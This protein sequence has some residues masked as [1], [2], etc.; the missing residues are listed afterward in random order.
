MY[1]KKEK[2]NMKK[3][4]ISFLLVLL[5]SVSL[6]GSILA[7][8]EDCHII[9]YESNVFANVVKGGTMSLYFTLYTTGKLEQ[10]YCVDICNSSGAAVISKTG[11]FSSTPGTE[12][13]TIS[14]DT[15]RYDFGTYTVKCYTLE[16]TTPVPDTMQTFTVSVSKSATPLKRLY[17]ADPSKPD[18][19]VTAVT[20]PLNER[21]SAYTVVFDPQNT[22]FKRDLTVTSSNPSAVEV[23]TSGGQIQFSA[24]GYGSSIITARTSQGYS[25]T[26]TVTVAKYATGI[27]IVLDSLDLPIGNTEI[28]E[29]AYTPA[30][31]TETA[32]TWSSSDSSIVSVSSTGKLTALKNGTATVTAC[33]YGQSDTCVVTVTGNPLPFTDVTSGKWY[34]N[35]VRYVY[36]NDLFSGMSPTEFGP[37]METTRAML[38]TVLWR[39]DGTPN[40]ASSSGFSDVVSNKYYTQAVAWASENNISNGISETEF[41]PELTLTREQTA[42]LLYRYAAYKGLDT[43]AVADLSTFPDGESV[44]GWALTA[45]RWAVGEELL[46]GTWTGESVLL[47]PQGSATRAQVATIIMRADF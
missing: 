37:D 33:C 42:T 17:F 47:D 13:L 44:S 8:E 34:H 35:A 25:C 32:T 18:T 21:S 24:V 20:I 4:L 39:L 45:M 43:S 41:G 46:A 11:N 22:T 12:E 40:P 9:P 30:D 6:C 26:C 14:W 1:V 27:D 5:L 28:L 31:A 2:N 38:I 19:A 3:R 36:E 7:V 10:S 23:I 16:G 29:V 15:G